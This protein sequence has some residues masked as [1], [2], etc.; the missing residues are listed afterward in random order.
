MA[1]LKKYNLQSRELGVI[2]VEDKLLEVKAHPQSIKDYIVA[3]RN[4]ARQW[5]ASTLNR[6]EVNKTGKKP[7][8][9]KGLG[10]SR[11]GC[12]AA[13]H[14]KGGGIAFGPRPKFDQ[15]VRI[16]K[17]ERRAAIASLLAEKIRE[18]RVLVLQQSDLKEPKTKTVAEFLKGLKL[19]GKRV[20]FLGGSFDAMEMPADSQA[21]RKSVRNLPKVEFAMVPNLN[22][23]DVMLSGHIV[24]LD[25]AVNELIETLR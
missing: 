22:A 24:L 23:Y 10:R 3:M 12:L 2:P 4:N 18:D 25:T 1:N 16:N 5:S 11:Q 19:N 8:Q 6:S 15:H 14:Y 21:V 9:Q 20:L 17:K 7:H 13:P